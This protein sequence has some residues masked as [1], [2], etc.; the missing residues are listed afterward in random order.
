MGDLV[1]VTAVGRLPVAPLLA[2]DRPK[3]AIRIGPLIPD[4]DLAVFE[5]T[6]VGVAAD[7]PQQ[8]DNDRPQV[9]LLG[10]QKRETFSKV[11]PHLSAEP[12]QSAGPG[13]V[14]LLD[15]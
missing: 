14:L 3:V 5:P 9:E 13:A 7:E 6:N 2:V 10:R 11:E 4:A 1:D 8:L 12:G 15:A